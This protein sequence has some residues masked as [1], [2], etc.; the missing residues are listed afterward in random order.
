MLLNDLTQFKI[1]F[2]SGNHFTQLLSKLVDLVSYIKSKHC[3]GF[4]L[5][6]LT[7]KEMTKIHLNMSSANNCLTLPTKLSIEAN[8][9]DPD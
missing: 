3:L 5:N 2:F 1:I 4:D 6:I 8:S 9:V 7:L